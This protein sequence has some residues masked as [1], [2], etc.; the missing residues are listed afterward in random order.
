MASSGVDSTWGSAGDGAK[1]KTGCPHCSAD[2][3]VCP[4]PSSQRPSGAGQRGPGR[5]A[6]FT[7]K[8]PSSY[9]LASG[10]NTA[11]ITFAVMTVLR[12]AAGAVGAGGW[13][14]H[15]IP[16]LDP[17]A[18]LLND[19]VCLL[20]ATHA[21][22]FRD[23]GGKRPLRF[24]SGPEFPVLRYCLIR[25]LSD[26]ALP[27]EPQVCRVQNPR[28]RGPARGGPRLVPRRSRGRQPQPRLRVWLVQM[29]A[30]L[31]PKWVPRM[32]EQGAP[33]PQRVRSGASSGPRAAVVLCGPTVRTLLVASRE[34]TGEAGREV[35]G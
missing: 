7:C 11:K 22:H 28:C 12:A 9:D 33:S 24:E 17:P 3:T 34:V 31:R 32:R 29:R 14:T 26:P 15:A 27:G 23:S 13:H 19:I 6:R 30:G 21:T 18:T 10:R 16:G 20:R 1:E 35:D 25:A 4:P 5:H 8:R 2:R